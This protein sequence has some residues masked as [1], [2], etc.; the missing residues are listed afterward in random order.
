MRSI[1]PLLVATG[2]VAAL[3]LTATACGPSE[4][5]AAD[6]PAAESAGGNGT[7]GGISA[8]LAETLKK[9]G[10]NP[11]KWKNGEWKNWDKD[12]WLREAKDFV[13]P[14]ID[15]LWQPDRM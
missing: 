3:A 10:V 6:K 2:L 8:D 1:R 15:G 9:H 4:D 11:E 5:K 7:G 13:N 12:K 14:V